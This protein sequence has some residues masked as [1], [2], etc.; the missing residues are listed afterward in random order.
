MW[1]LIWIICIL[2]LLIFIIGG[3][4]HITNNKNV[5]DILNILIGILLVVVGIFVASIKGSGTI[6]PTFII[7]YAIFLICISFIV[8]IILNDVILSSSI[9]VIY[10]GFCIVAFGIL[11]KGIRDQ[12]GM[13]SL[14]DRSEQ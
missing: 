1:K 6:N 9:G 14:N 5:S 7:Y 8:I 2:A 13:S 10:A 12:K 3:I 4:W 11:I